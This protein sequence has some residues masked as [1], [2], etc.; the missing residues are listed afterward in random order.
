[1][2]AEESRYVLQEDGWRSV[3]LHKVE[4]GIGE[5]AAFSGESATLA[6][7]REVLAGESSGPEEGILP[8]SGVL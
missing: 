3:A 8:T 1:V 5:S 6:C 7:D 2:A 4:E